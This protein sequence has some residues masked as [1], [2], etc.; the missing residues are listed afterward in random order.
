MAGGAERDGGVP[1][2]G[3]R[4]SLGIVIGLPEGL[5]AELGGWRASFGDP[6]AA[7][8]PPHITLVTGT[9]PGGWD[10]AAEHARAVAARREPFRLTLR[11]TGT[12]RPVSPV[13]YL[14]VEEG[15]DECV[16]LHADLRGGPVEHESGFDYHPHLTLAQD[17]TEA[18][19]DHALAALDGF[20]ASFTVSSIGLFRHDARG[21][22][23]L[24]E[25][26]PLG[27]ATPRP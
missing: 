20:S 22:W 26:V 16:G 14:R 4:Q 5:S 25:D 18:G 24:G 27:A 9:A 7:V 17:V 23:S 1:G 13:V 6:L 8:V 11:G 2:N 19:M 15:W 3:A 21:L 10:A 12:F